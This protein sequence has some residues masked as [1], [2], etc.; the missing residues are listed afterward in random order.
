VTTQKNYKFI[1]YNKKTKTQISGT[2]LRNGIDLNINGGVDYNFI[3]E[4]L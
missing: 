3:I 4:T 1:D 2:Q